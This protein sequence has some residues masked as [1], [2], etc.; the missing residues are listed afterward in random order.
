MNKKLF[1]TIG[2]VL[3]LIAAALVYVVM[4]KA[5]SSTDKTAQSQTQ[6]KTTPSPAPQL[7]APPPAAATPGAYVVYSNEAFAATPGTKLLFF[8]APWCPQCR[9]LEA[10]IKS[11]PLPANV[12]VFK[13]DYDSNQALR[14]KYGVTLQTTFVKVNDAGEKVKS[15][16]AYNE[17]TFEAVKRELLP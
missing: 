2:L 11:N 16:V 8:H 7:H 10:T 9:E 13:V 15:Y 3:A 17:P 14:Q 12:T 5:D 4:Q 1:T 6:S